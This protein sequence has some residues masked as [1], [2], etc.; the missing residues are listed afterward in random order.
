[1]FLNKFVCHEEPKKKIQVLKGK[2]NLRY[3]FARQRSINKVLSGIEPHL[4]F[5]FLYHVFAHFSRRT[6]DIN[7][8]HRRRNA[9]AMSLQK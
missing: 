6:I 4:L 7:N 1:M 9:A 8:G 2:Q 5:D 3:L